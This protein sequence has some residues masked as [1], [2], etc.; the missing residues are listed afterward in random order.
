MVARN[1][2]LPSGFS[3]MLGELEKKWLALSPLDRLELVER[4]LVFLEP[5]ASSVEPLPSSVLEL[6]FAR[7]VQVE[8]LRLIGEG[9]FA[10][11]C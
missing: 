5:G 4:S 3:A 1:F 2:A 6:A 8:I 7:F 9:G 11:P 10:P